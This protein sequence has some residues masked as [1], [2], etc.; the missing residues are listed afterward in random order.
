MTVAERAS[1]RERFS[2]IGN[3]SEV[4]RHFGRSRGTIRAAL[5]W[6][7]KP[8]RRASKKSVLLRRAAL[9]V[10]AKKTRIVGSRTFPKFGSAARIACAYTSTTGNPISKRQVCRDLK[11]A[12]MRPF[13]RPRV[14]TRDAA[15]QA[16]RTAF[17]RRLLRFRISDPFW[18][19]VVF[20]DESWLTCN[21]MT[22]S[23][24]WAFGKKFVYPLE[25]KSKWNVPSLQVWA[26]VGWGFK[27][28]LVFFPAA[29]H[30]VEGECRAFRLD[31]HAYI[32]RCLI[33]VVPEL[34]RRKSVFQ[35]DG[36]RSHSAKNVRA[37]LRKRGVECLEQWPPYS[38]DLNMIEPLWKEL[39]RRVG[40]YCPMTIPELLA[41]GHRAWAELPQSMIDAHVMGFRGKLRVC[42]AL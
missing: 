26:A 9:V 38:P 34:V 3:V 8:K 35:Q 14:P 23:V 19:R 7:S 36:A 37:Y 24:Q 32:R 29:M 21:E 18:K 17:A 30:T 22:S 39:K 27:S 25:K 28:S 31:S 15:E 5:Q 41:A 13:K 40:E 6:K 12:G 4:A 42:L 20:S 1:I 33:S 16:T 10:L 11:S 2:L